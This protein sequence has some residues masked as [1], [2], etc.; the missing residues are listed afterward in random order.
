MSDSRCWNHVFNHC[1]KRSSRGGG[2]GVAERHGLR[3]SV[4]V[5]RSV[6]LVRAVVYGSS[7]SH[8]H[9]SWPKADSK[10]RTRLRHS[11][12]KCGLISA[13]H[14]RRGSKWTRGCWEKPGDCA[15]DAWR[16]WSAVFKGYAG[17]AMPRLQ[18]LNDS[19]QEFRDRNTGLPL[20][21]ETVKMAR[22][23]EMQYIDELEVLED[24]NRD[25]CT[26]ETGRPPIPD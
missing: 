1:K 19:A 20:T 15:Q 23:L 11:N 22:E 7:H 4:N 3:V 2:R 8:T 14:R 10:Q 13:G 9:Q 25:T 24:S 6:G 18:K 21:L 16:D 26:A 12:R 17:A 5:G